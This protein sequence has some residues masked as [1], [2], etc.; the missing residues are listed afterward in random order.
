MLRMPFLTASDN[1]LLDGA[2]AFS[3]WCASRTRKLALVY[4]YTS[5]ALNHWQMQRS[6]SKLI[7]LKWASD[8][9][10]YLNSVIWMWL[11]CSVQRKSSGCICCFVLSALVWDCTKE[12]W[13]N[14]DK[15]VFDGNEGHAWGQWLHIACSLVVTVRLNPG[16]WREGNVLLGE[17]LSKETAT[18]V[19]KSTKCLSIPLLLRK[20][21]L[22]KRDL[23][24]LANCHAI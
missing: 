12:G 11:S 2:V 24:E 14:S 6:H 20:S 13:A 16:A 5:S 1:T 7:C 9:S 18:N 17:C 21:I 22:K 19:A 15:L 8:D 10:I 3:K 23:P 4:K